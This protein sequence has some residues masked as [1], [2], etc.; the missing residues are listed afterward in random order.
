MKNIR[1]LV[2]PAALVALCSCAAR[3]GAPVPARELA[4]VVQ[5]RVFALSRT[6]DPDLEL[7]LPDL[8]GLSYAYVVY[9]MTVPPDSGFTYT[10]SPKGAIYPFSQVEI[11]CSM[12]KKFAERY[13]EEI[14]SA[15]L[16]DL[17]KRIAQ[18]IKDR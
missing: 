5:T 14:C 6:P 8:A 12:R 9:T 1:F 15:F 18:T 11:N 13:G 16:S 3:Q 17:G 10:L 7:A 2:L 4:A